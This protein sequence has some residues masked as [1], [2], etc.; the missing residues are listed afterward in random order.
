MRFGAGWP[1]G[2][3][4]ASVDHRRESREPLQVIDDLGRIFVSEIYS[5]SFTRDV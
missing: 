3:H 5:S 1:P 4:Q 2:R